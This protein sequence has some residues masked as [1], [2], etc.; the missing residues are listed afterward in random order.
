M[1]QIY[2]EAVNLI[3]K[4]VAELI[5]ML[6]FAGIDWEDF[7][8]DLDLPEDSPIDICFSK[9]EIVRRLFL[10]HTHNSGGTSTGNLKRLLGIKGEM[11]QF[12]LRKGE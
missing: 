5:E 12:I 2:Q 8:R 1:K 7:R 4:I 6:E 11:E 9:S 10:S 3:N